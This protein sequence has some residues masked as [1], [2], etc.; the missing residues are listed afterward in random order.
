GG[1]EYRGEHHDTVI[2]LSRRGIVN[3]ICSKNDY[4]AVCQLLTERGIWDYFVF[5]KIAW[6][7]KGEMIAQTIDQMGLRAVNT[8]FV[9]DN[10][11]NLEEAKFYNPGI[12]VA[13][14]AELKDLWGQAA[15]Q[16]KDDAA[17]SRLKQYQLLEK[18]VVDRQQ[19]ASGNEAFLR[20]C[21][22]RVDV[23]H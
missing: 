20:Q 18:K 8:L 16:G 10:P 5:P 12:Q 14:P 17:L 21:D 4:D 9:A 19:F 6:S 22:I 1:I 2:E 7:P 3:S 11:Q 13:S 15:A 23:C